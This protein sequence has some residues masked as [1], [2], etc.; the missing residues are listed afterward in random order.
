MP[1]NISY[2]SFG[3]IAVQ[4]QFLCFIMNIFT[5][6]FI[7]RMATIIYL[8]CLAS[9]IIVHVVIFR[10]QVAAIK[11]IIEFG[12]RV[13]FRDVFRQNNKY[14]SKEYIQKMPLPYTVINNRY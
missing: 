12:Q 3:A 5:C 10:D 2:L 7:L 6:L 11:S 1:C 13:R 9:Y 4:L 8:S 14:N